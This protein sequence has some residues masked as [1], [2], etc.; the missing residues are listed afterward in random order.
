M[1]SN[2]AQILSNRPRHAENSDTRQ[3]IKR[4]DP[5]QER[6]KKDE[7]DDDKGV[8]FDTYDNA[9]I[10]VSALRVFLENFLNSLTGN[11]ATGGEAIALSAQGF[12]AAEGADATDHKPQSAAASHAA[13]VY[14]MAAKTARPTP[15]PV[16]K[17][18]EPLLG[19]EDVRTIHRLMNETLV[20]QSR[21][22][23]YLTI[24]RGET[25]LASLAAAVAKAL[26]S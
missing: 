17:P 24:E 12:D 21:G 4:H 2:L 14:Q 7:K 20:L 6:R 19:N 9:V 13:N 10:S 11:A 25:F 5:D 26:Q 15:V 8:R 23:E 3:E 1:F 16:A 22:I 18:A